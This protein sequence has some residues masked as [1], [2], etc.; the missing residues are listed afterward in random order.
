MVPDAKSWRRIRVMS[1]SSSGIMCRVKPFLVLLGRHM[2]VHSDGSAEDVGR[3]VAGQS[4]ASPSRYTWTTARFVMWLP[5]SLVPRAGHR[6]TGLFI[7]FVCQALS[8]KCLP[9]T[10]LLILSLFLHQLGLAAHRRSRKLKVRA[11][12]LSV[13]IT[14]ALITHSHPLWPLHKKL[15][16]GIKYLLTW[17]CNTTT[18]KDK[19]SGETEK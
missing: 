8:T 4:S 14:S 7:S 3:A 2:E 11:A 15:V 17:P 12:H 19:Y 5:E 13:T 10:A 9:S 18:H 1:S 16:T 6:K